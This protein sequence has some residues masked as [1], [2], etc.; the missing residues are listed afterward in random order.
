MQTGLLGTVTSIVGGRGAPGPAH[1]AGGDRPPAHVPRDARRRRRR[2]RDGDLLARARAAARRRDP[3]RGRGVHQPHARTTS[4]STRTMEDYFLAKRLLFASARRGVRIANADDAYGRRLADGVPGTRDVRR[5]TREAD[6]RARRRALRR[7][8]AATSRCVTPDG[9]FAVRVPLPGRF[10]VL[11]RAR[12]VGGGAGARRRAGAAARRAG[13]RRRACPGASSRST[14][15]SRSRSSSTTRTSR[16][17]SRTCCRRR[18][19]SPTGGVIVVF[20]AGGDRDRGKRPLM[21]EIARAAR[22][23]GDHHLRQPALRGPGGD[24]RRDRRRQARRG[25][26]VERRRPPRGDR[27][28]DRAR[29][30]GRRRRDRRQGPRAGPGVRGR[31]QGAV[32]RRRGRPRGAAALVARA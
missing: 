7:R 6:Y 31:A 9:E 22:R 27:P 14:R 32:R 24:H 3:L 10:N 16:T 4:T 8:R 15:A 12:R 18:A 19:S 11:E 28:R 5:S 17:R 23:R 13:R 29:R 25:G 26:V 1:D 20:G 2:L 21:G 30:A